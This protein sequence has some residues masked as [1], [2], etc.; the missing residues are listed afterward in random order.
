MVSTS[1]VPA[2]LQKDNHE[3]TISG[4][5]GTAVSTKDAESG[6]MT[7]VE[8]DTPGKD[9]TP[10]MGNNSTSS[11][12]NGKCSKV[13]NYICMAISAFLFI[14]FVASSVVQD[15]DTGGSAI[16][17]LLFYALHA[18]VAGLYLLS[19]C[20]CTQRCA[21]GV[22]A[23]GVGMFVWSVVFVIISS[24]QVSKLT[25]A[26]DIVEEGGDNPHATKKEEIAYEIAGAAL[27]MC[28]TMYHIFMARKASSSA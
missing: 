23:L 6:N 2:W 7:S 3:T 10:T 19:T 11:T 1:E 4:E 24:V 13:C 15:N 26:D 17:Y 21:K 5:I 8:I 25:P 28:S 9:T 22:I 27:G 12:T 18:I 14:L 16:V 20:L